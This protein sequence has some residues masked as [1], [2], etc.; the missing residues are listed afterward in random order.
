[1]AQ[2]LGAEAGGMLTPQEKRRSLPAQTSRDRSRRG[3][4]ES[5]DSCQNDAG[6]EVRFSNN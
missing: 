6:D 4:R 1:M 5:L 2:I 3:S